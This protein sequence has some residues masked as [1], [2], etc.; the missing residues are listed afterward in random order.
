MVLYILGIF[1]AWPIPLH[2][3]RCNPIILAHPKLFRMIFLQKSIKT[4][5]FNF[6]EN[7]IL[8][9]N[10]GEGGMVNWKSCKDFHLT[11]A[12]KTNN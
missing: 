11:K 10:V 6:L 7:D 1:V 12:L 3:G 2:K 5:N 8:T 4:K 9:K